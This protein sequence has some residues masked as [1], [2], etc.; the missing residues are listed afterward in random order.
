MNKSIVLTGAAVAA[1]AIAGVYVYSQRPLTA[2]EEV[3]DATCADAPNG[4]ACGAQALGMQCWRGACGQNLCGDGIVLGREQCD[5]GNQGDGD[6]C[7]A[8]CRWEPLASCGDGTR[9]R[10]EECDD[11]NVVDE[12]GCNL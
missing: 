10:F 8:A 7:S 2:P 9:D 3:S 4:T 11:G 5:D 12:D 1:S 6:G